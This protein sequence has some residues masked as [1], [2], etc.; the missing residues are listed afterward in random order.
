MSSK[1]GLD[2]N[3]IETFLKTDEPFDTVQKSLKEL[4]KYGINGVPSFIIGDK[5]IV[6]AQPYEI[7]KK[8]INE[9]LNE[10][11]K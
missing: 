9:I 2:K 11:S 10:K 8:A 6:G 4:R 3:E 5:L 1:F 7:F